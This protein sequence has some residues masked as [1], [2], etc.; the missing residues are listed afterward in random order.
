MPNEIQKTQTPPAVVEEKG[1][2]VVALPEG[3]P[4]AV[5][6]NA[7]V[8]YGI[9]ASLL[10]VVAASLAHA[11]RWFAGALVFALGCCLTGFALQLMK[12]NIRDKESETRKRLSGGR[13]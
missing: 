7:T 12:P 10:F 5:L 6:P 8:I 11:G 3:K 9:G 4:G 13:G 1:D 2:L